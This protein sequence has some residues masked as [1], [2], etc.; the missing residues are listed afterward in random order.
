MVINKNK[1]MAYM[2]AYLIGT[3]ETTR[4][5]IKIIWW[6]LWWGGGEKSRHKKS[7]NKLM[8]GL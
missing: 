1:T 4:A 3:M 2:I 7:P 6:R 5:T 8:K